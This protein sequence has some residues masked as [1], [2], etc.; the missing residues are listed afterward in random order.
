MFDEI[1][2]RGSEGWCRLCRSNPLMDIG[3]TTKSALSMLMFVAQY[4]LNSQD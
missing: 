4:R 3:E 2:Q 1:P